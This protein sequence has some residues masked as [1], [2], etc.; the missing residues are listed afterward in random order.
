[1]LTI[2]ITTRNYCLKLK[3]TRIRNRDSARI[4]PRLNVTSVQIAD[5]TLSLGFIP[6]MA[7]DLY[8]DIAKL[9]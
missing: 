3:I 8:T 2:G 1:M 7:F 4:K 5:V 6:P 9:S